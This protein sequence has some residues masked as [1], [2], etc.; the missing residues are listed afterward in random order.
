MWVT[1]GDTQLVVAVTDER[2]LLFRATWFL[3]RNSGELLQEFDLDKVRTV[4][5][6]TSY[7]LLGIPVVRTQLEL[8]DGQVV[9]IVSPGIAFRHA[10]SVAKALTVHIGPTPP[11]AGDLSP[12]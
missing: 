3:S 5:S 11:N 7:L 1:E 2:V 4:N 9:Q 8:D 10:R 6:K 12:E